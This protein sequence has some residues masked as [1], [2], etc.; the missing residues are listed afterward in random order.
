MQK[1]RNK[2]ERNFNYKLFKKNSKLLYKLKKTLY[3][4][5]SLKSGNFHHR[6]S[7]LFFGIIRIKQKN[8]EATDQDMSKSPRVL[9][10]V[11]PFPKG[12]NST[13]GVFSLKTFYE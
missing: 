9:F 1:F 13:T 11:I 4:K 10:H 7:F 3:L 8:E 6:A 2:N 5:L 12:K